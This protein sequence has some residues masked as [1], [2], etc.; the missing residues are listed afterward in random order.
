MHK[1]NMKKLASIIAALTIPATNVAAGDF[2][3]A[4]G[5][6]D[7]SDK[8]KR[9]AMLELTYGFTEKNIDSKIG[10]IQPIAGALFTADSAGM[11]YIGAKIDYKLGMF[12]ITPSFTPGL[13]NEGSGKDLGHVVEF[14]SQV[15][16]GLNLGASS[17]LSAGYS[18]ISNASL[19]EKN[20]GANSYTFNF[21]TQ[22]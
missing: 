21:S 20:P 12:V 8:G 5:N 18:H 4:V 19:G 6:F 10:T 14:K 13:Y 2:N 1:Q 22:F 9:A 3:A 7:F 16:I 15:N 11:A 17:I